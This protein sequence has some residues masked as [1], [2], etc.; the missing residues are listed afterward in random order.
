MII[1]N[2]LNIL[3]PAEVEVMYLIVLIFCVL[4]CAKKLQTALLYTVTLRAINLLLDVLGAVLTKNNTLQ[5]THAEH[6]LL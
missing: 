6:P 4:I 2:N 3:S 5:H 1:I